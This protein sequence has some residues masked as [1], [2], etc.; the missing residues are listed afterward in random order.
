MNYHLEK[1]H[2]KRLTF[3]VKNIYKRPFSSIPLRSISVEHVQSFRTWLLSSK[4]DGGEGYSQSYASLI[5]GAFRKSLDKAVEMQYLEHNLS[6]NVKA[7][8]KGKAIVQYWSKS[9]FEKVIN[10]IYIE[11]FYEHLNFVML[12]VYHMLIVKSRTDWKRNSYT[13]TE[14]GKLD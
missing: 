8:Q 12:W 2:K 9:E 7:I 3:C 11:D 14:N 4:E 10:K 1:L 13:K 6:K 5:F